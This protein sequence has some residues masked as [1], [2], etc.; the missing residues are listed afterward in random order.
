[1]DRSRSPRVWW[2]TVG[3]GTTLVVLALVHIVANHFVVDEPGG[4]RTY[5]QILDYIAHPAIL[6]LEAVFLVTVTIH[7]MLGLRG[8]LLDLDPG[9]R[10]RLWLD[11]ALWGLGSVTVVYGLFLLVALASRA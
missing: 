3:T 5:D 8:V 1:M 6:A 9:V 4:L 7:A 11:R 10:V 2:W